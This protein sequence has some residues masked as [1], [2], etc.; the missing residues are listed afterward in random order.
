MIT[1]SWYYNRLITSCAIARYAAAP[2]LFLSYTV[3]DKPKNYEEY[4]DLY[5]RVLKGK[6]KPEEI[7]GEGGFID[8]IC[9]KLYGKEIAKEL[10]RV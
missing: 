9:E 3:T 1:L 10:S 5:K 7:Y 2:R 8:V 6:V 4:L